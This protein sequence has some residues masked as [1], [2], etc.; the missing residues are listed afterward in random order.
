MNTPICSKCT[1]PSSVSYEL[2]RFT[3]DK[4]FLRTV[5]FPCMCGLKIN[6]NWSLNYKSG[7]HIDI[8]SFQ[9]LFFVSLMFWYKFTTCKYAQRLNTSVTD[10]SKCHEIDTG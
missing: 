5:I 10:V 2:P 8:V 4:Q 1:G 3:R 7:K 6:G 9:S